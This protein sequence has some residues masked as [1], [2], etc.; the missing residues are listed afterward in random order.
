[1]VELVGGRDE[2]MVAEG[3]R[4]PCENIYFIILKSMNTC[5]AYKYRRK[6][7]FTE[8][9]SRYATSQNVHFFQAQN[10][11]DF[12]HSS[13]RVLNNIKGKHSLAPHIYFAFL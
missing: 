6:N 2:S 10:G 9:V 12:S 11:M 5:Y 7:R 4:E 1:M 13:P 3:T 8:T